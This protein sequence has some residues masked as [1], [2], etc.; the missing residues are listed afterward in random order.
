MASHP[1]E[2]SHRVTDGVNSN[3]PHVK[4]AGRVRKHGE[5]I[6]LLPVGIL[7]RQEGT[8]MRKEE[9]AAKTPQKTFQWILKV[10]NPGAGISIS[11][12]DA[13]GGLKWWGHDSDNKPSHT[14]SWWL[15]RLIRWSWTVYSHNT[16]SLETQHR[17]PCILMLE[18]AAAAANSSASTAWDGQ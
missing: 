13:S 2:V 10:D 18:A 15:W 16:V 5:D 4:A 7:R 17:F 1:L 12:A 11:S 8:D 3:M 14:V 6:K 9:T